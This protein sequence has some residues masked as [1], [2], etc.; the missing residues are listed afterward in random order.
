MPEPITFVVT[1][2]SGATGTR[3]GP[4]AGLPL[5]GKIKKSI[6]L[7]ARRGPQE[8]DERLTAV[9][10]DD[11]VLLHIAGGPTLWL[12]PEHARELLLAQDDPAR[13][14]SSVRDPEANHGD[15]RVPARLQWG[16]EEAAVTSGS[17]RGLGDVLVRAIEIAGDFVEDAKDFVLGGPVEF[18]EDKLTGAVEGAI[19]DPVAAASRA[20]TQSTIDLMLLPP[21]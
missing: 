15:V 5:G 7:T 21:P 4:D 3:G 10:G 14:R 13:P 1:G 18:V 17:T 2:V 19:A 11:V 12:H 16:L 8:T 20:P 6:D 9:P